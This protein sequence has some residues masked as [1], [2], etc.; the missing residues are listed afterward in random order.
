MRQALHH[1]SFLHTP[2][3]FFP[4]TRTKCTFKSS[5]HGSI[6]SFSFPSTIVPDHYS[7]YLNSLA[8]SKP[9]FKVILLLLSSPIK[10]I[11]TMI[12]N[13]FQKQESSSYSN[14]FKTSSSCT[15]E[16]TWLIYS[17]PLVQITEY[18]HLHKMTTAA[19]TQSHG[20]AVHWN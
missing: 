20:S 3:N 15:R 1:V 2:V 5:F 7:K 12:A 16:S 8:T 4:F 11:C 18:P 9:P 10:V 14:L 6:F 13:H 19:F 17:T